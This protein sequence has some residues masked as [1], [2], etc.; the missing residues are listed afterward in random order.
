MSNLSKALAYYQAINDKTPEK[1]AEY[2]H[3]DIEISTPLDGQKG[4]EQV[5][6]A[7]RGFS[8]VAE[9]IVIK[10]RLMQGSQV[11]LTYEIQFPAP[12]G[13]LKAAGLLEFEDGLI[14]HIELYYDP[15]SLLT[16]RD[17]IFNP[18]K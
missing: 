10:A 11:M 15:R 7:L 3:D 6:N 2:L 17:D 5:K 14:R 16:L 9:S 1:A 4:K 18:Q 8:Q 13:K 12:A